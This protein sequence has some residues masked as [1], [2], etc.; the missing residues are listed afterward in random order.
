M[1]GRQL[2]FF[3]QLLNPVGQSDKTQHVG[4]VAAA[5]A[6]ILPQLFLGIGKFVDQ[7][8]ITVGLF[9]RGEVL[10]LKVFNQR[11]LEGL[12]VAQILDDN[13][14]FMKLGPLGGPPAPFPGNDFIGNRLFRVAA[15]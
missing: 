8:L 15:H 5:L 14:N 10:P 6:Q 1:A 4:H 2:A 12:A 11:Q 3:N 7:A 13:R 9:D